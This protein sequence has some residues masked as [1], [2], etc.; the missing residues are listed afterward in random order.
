MSYRCH[1]EYAEAISGLSRWE[2]RMVTKLFRA[3]TL[4][5]VMLVNSGSSGM[6]ARELN[7]LPKSVVRCSSEYL[8]ITVAP[9]FFSNIFA[10]ACMKHD[11]CYRF[12]ATTYGYSRKHCDH[13]FRKD[14]LAICEPDSW[15]EWGALVGTAGA[16]ASACMLAANA[17]F[18]SVRAAGSSAFH[19]SSLVCPYETIIPVRDHRGMG[20]AGGGGGVDLNQP[21]KKQN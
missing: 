14:M 21:P 10:N 9:I 8:D 11:F 1:V 16:S 13:Q 17:Y 4:S 18:L 3:A 6:A 5:A 20:K 12:G 15:K 7:C 19:K 2:A